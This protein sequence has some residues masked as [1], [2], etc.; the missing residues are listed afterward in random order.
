MSMIAQSYPSLDT[1][2][3]TGEVCLFKHGHPL[4]G[5]GSLVW[6]LERVNTPAPVALAA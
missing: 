4:D 3:E 6:F 5:G 2:Y 1:F